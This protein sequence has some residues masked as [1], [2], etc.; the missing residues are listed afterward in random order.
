MSTKSIIAIS[1]AVSSAAAF[2]SPAIKRSNKASELAAVAIEDDR[3]IFDPFNLYPKNS[4]EK[5]GGR[6]RAL[7][8]DVEVIKPVI[9]PLDLYSKKNADVDQDVVMSEAIPF[10]P[11]PIHL[12]GALAGDVGF[13]PL[14]LA[15]T[16]E[17]LDF[18]REAELKHSRI[19]MLATSGWVLSELCNGPIAEAF[20]VSTI[21]GEGDRAPSVLNGGLNAV[22]PVFWGVVL[23]MAAGL[24]YGQMHNE[25]VMFDPLNLYQTDSEGRKQLQTMELSHGRWAMLAITGFA[26]QEW[27]T[28]DAVVDQTPVFFHSGFAV[29]EW[30]WAAENGYIGTMFSH[31]I[32][33]GGF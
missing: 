8:P 15:T 4:A 2:Q 33:H 11:R 28:K 1:L 6:I 5:L 9:D 26:I 7:E 19:A 17:R 21:L 23:G 29:H 16:A 12:T 25:P 18:M 24:E 31:L 30:V 20:G 13:D 10:V 22:S 32:N 27:V 3:P 14:N